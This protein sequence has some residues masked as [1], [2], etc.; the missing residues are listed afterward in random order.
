MNQEIATT[1]NTQPLTLTTGAPP[2]HVEA[3]LALLLAEHYRDKPPATTI[4]LYGV[5]LA[6]YPAELLQVAAVECV[7][8]IK[9]FP[10]VNEIEQIIHM[11]RELIESDQSFR[12]QR[13]VF[14]AKATINARGELAEFHAR[15]KAA[16]L[17]YIERERAKQHMQDQC[18]TRQRNEAKVADMDKR[19]ANAQ[20]RLDKAVS[21]G[22]ADGV[23]YLTDYI[24][25]CEARRVE[26][27]R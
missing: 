27:G 26:Q 13:R 2:P 16:T 5:M 23:E 8:Q 24:A 25:F 21:D 19:I 17:A 15:C 14:E 10:K 7:N 4:R 1:T 22:N 20:A 18:E 12:Y 11:I 3:M 6:E 9:W